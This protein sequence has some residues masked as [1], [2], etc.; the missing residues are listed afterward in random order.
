MIRKIR[1]GT[2]VKDIHLD[3][4]FSAGGDDFYVPVSI[5]PSVARSVE[6]KYLFMTFL[7]ENIRGYSYD[8]VTT[9]LKRKPLFIKQG[10]NKMSLSSSDVEENSTN[11]SLF[12]T[13][14][15]SNIVSSMGSQDNLDNLITID[16]IYNIDTE[17]ARVI[18]R[19]NYIAI[20]NITL[21]QE[22]D[23][24]R[25][26]NFIVT[27]FVLN[28]KLEIIDYLSKTSSQSVKNFENLNNE[29]NED[30]LQNVLYE[31]S[32]QFDFQFNRY[33]FPLSQRLT[34][35]N[36]I[37][38]LRYTINATEDYFFQKTEEF[39]LFKRISIRILDR[40]TERSFLV[41][42]FRRSNFNITPEYSR[43][44]LQSSQLILFVES[45]YSY[46]SGENL[47][48]TDVLDF[49]MQFVAET[50]EG[51]EVFYNRQKLVSFGSIE[52]L[53]QDILRY[54]IENEM[55]TG[56]IVNL[57][58]E[59]FNQDNF[60]L[61]FNDAGEKIEVVNKNKYKIQLNLN[62]Q[63]V[64]D[65]LYDSS[66]RLKFYDDEG[67]EINDISRLYYDDNLTL[68]ND[69]EIVDRINVKNVMLNN[70][71]IEFYF[72]SDELVKSANILFYYNNESTYYN[73]G[74]F[75]VTDYLGS[76][77]R[78]T[79]NIYDQASQEIGKF[80]TYNSLMPEDV[81]N[82]CNGAASNFDTFYIDTSMLVENINLK[83]LS[84]FEIENTLETT[85]ILSI[86]RRFF[87]NV[88][89]RINKKI[90]TSGIEVLNLN[91]YC[92][93]TDVVEEFETQENKI[94]ARINTRNFESVARNVDYSASLVNR[95]D[96]LRDFQ[97]I[98]TRGNNSNVSSTFN[99]S[100]TNNMTFLLLKNKTSEYFGKG[101]ELG[102]GSDTI[103]TAKR[104]LADFVMENYTNYSVSN[105]ESLLNDLFD[106]TVYSSRKTELLRSLFVDSNL[107]SHDVMVTRTLRAS[108][109]QNISINEN[110]EVQDTDEESE[111][112]QFSNVDF[113][114][115]SSDS[116]FNIQSGLQANLTAGNFILSN[117]FGNTFDF[118]ISGNNIQ[119]LINQRNA[120]NITSVTARLSFN[121]IFN[122]H[123]R[124]KNNI[125]DD[126]TVH[127]IPDGRICIS[128]ENSNFINL[129]TT[130]SNN[131]ISLKAP[132]TDF[133]FDLFENETY[134][135]ISSYL[136]NESVLIVEN[137]IARVNIEFDYSG[138]RKSLS[139]SIIVKHSEA[140]ND[141]LLNNN[142]SSSFDKIN[143]NLL[144]PNSSY[145]MPLLIYK[146]S[147]VIN[148]DIQNRLSRNLNS[149]FLRGI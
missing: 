120:G 108:D 100:A 90:I 144:D 105:L 141:F 55:T 65:F 87:D 99:I 19:N 83:A 24:E 71:S 143:L 37:R 64:L 95:I 91:H 80:T 148:N 101:N 20:N 26:D 46:Y 6:A 11:N 81:V 28:E 77:A 123:T 12:K 38:G 147:S 9:S 50:Y 2:L 54:Q 130:F 116:E 31:V 115:Y 30:V 140:L 34:A 68:G 128:I 3:E 70:S 135:I 35:G 86:T 32:Q 48:S 59:H 61:T 63:G 84:Y 79:R 49:E 94:I 52:R 109:A 23:I 43:S 17:T 136:V 8:G 111:D 13:V 57:N 25:N 62:P 66:F 118:D 88:L 47:T 103:K 126:L 22:N 96:V 138:V 15:S 42:H 92:F 10:K 5:D 76:D 142:L 21:I 121:L 1:R 112:I 129:E 72:E 127:T 56:N 82:Y 69:I 107:T 139:R 124:F 117:T 18:T 14:Y 97:N 119:N 16:Y 106:N 29:V 131:S 89:V 146:K 137:I 74:P 4:A 73:I 149:Q 58:V 104:N 125:S 39:D 145:F 102:L 85:D 78:V 93:L 45:V 113:E 114:N 33:V 98:I 27:A 7:P 133:L 75:L 110:I 122:K 134:N 60:F 67:L 41:K 36:D 44:L 51:S 53:R 132:R 40:N